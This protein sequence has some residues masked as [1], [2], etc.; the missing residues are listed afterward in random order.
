MPPQITSSDSESNG[1]IIMP[2]K[3]RG[4]KTVEPVQ[5]PDSDQESNGDEEEEY[6]VEKITD[7]KFVSSKVGRILRTARPAARRRLTFVIFTRYFELC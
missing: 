1:D 3:A 6:V 4:S 5:E 7:H 2:K